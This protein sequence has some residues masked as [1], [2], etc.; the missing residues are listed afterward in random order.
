MTVAID[1]REALKSQRTGKGQWTQG[2]VTELISRRIP[3]VL[4]T[5]APLPASWQ[6]EHVR[7]LR[8]PPGPL[9]HWAVARAIRDD[10]SITHVVST[11]SFIVPALLPKHIM[12]LPVIHDLI[13]FAG[14]RHEWKALLIERMTLPRVLAK[15]THVLALS[16]ATKRDLLAR[17]PT[18]KAASV[19]VIGAGPT[20][21]P[22]TQMPPEESF[23]LC[24]GTLC[25]RKNQLRLIRAYASLPASMRARHPLLL[26]GGRGWQDREIIEA[27]R[28]T[29]GVQWKGYASQ[30]DYARLLRSC[31]FLA[32]PS[33]SE[34]FGMQVLDA[35][36]SGVPVLTSDRGSLKEVAGEAALIVDPE[37]EASIA[38]GLKKLLSDPSLRTE[39]SRHGREQAARYSWARTVDL[40]LRAVHP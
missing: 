39:L 19:T 20:L 25:P 37:S 2:F 4:L 9:W 32:H 13:A 27:A 8:K 38:Q 7:V 40:F 12:S 10:R 26:V 5:N 1:V 34:G 33:L 30:E 18:V 36:A 22:P 31:L 11:T 21:A 16:E 3:L 14:D 6:T 23:I 17:F 28:T 29:N 35:L 24:A 15:A